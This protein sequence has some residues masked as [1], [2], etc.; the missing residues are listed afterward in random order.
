[1]CCL[2]DA[3]GCRHPSAIMTARGLGSRAT[4]AL[5]PSPS[6]C[7]LTSCAAVVPSHSSQIALFTCSCDSLR[8]CPSPPLTSSTSHLRP[9]S[10]R[11]FSIISRFALCL[12][13]LRLWPSI[14]TED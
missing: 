1:M 14:T 7:S 6:Y 13:R 2:K 3:A 9:L 11:S 5:L 10:L 4:S 12:L 8:L